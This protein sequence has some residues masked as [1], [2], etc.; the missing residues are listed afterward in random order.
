MTAKSVY[1]YHKKSK[2]DSSVSR[3]LNKDRFFGDN[4]VNL[5]KSA[6]RL[7]DIKWP[8]TTIKKKKKKSN[9]RRKEIHYIFFSSRF[10]CNGKAFTKLN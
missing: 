1:R 10:N 6:Y 2:I 7:K 4:Y 8:D 9:M 5:F 3:F